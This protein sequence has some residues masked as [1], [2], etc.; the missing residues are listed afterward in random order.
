MPLRICTVVKTPKALLQ[1]TIETGQWPAKKGAGGRAP[2]HILKT[3][4]A[5][6]ARPYH[7][8]PLPKVFAPI[9]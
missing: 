7:V 4:D 8:D 1:W 6:A 9:D 5:R 3:S 2:V